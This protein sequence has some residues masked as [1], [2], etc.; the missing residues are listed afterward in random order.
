MAIGLSSVPRAPEGAP[1]TLAERLV[2][3]VRGEFNLHP[4]AIATN[5]ISRSLPQF[6]FNR[7]RTALLRVAGVSIG[8]RSA[9]MG[10]LSISGSGPVGLLSIGDDTAISG[11]LHVDLGARVYIGSR[12][13]FGHDVMLLTV[14]HELGRSGERCGRLIATPIRIEDGVWVASRVTILPGVSVGRGAVIAAGAVVVTDV[15]P[16]TLV[17]GVPAKV[18]RDLGSE[19]PPS[20]ARRSR[21]P[22]AF[23]G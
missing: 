15:A 20:S 21:P 1:A 5:A 16:D 17:G 22:V 13:H 18:V 7:T 3:V 11:P 10:S 4:R 2:R 14:N 23:G 12:V 6:S 8:A 19:G 9:V